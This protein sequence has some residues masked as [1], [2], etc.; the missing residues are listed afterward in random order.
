MGCVDF[1]QDK[2]RWRA[3]LNSHEQPGSTKCGE[4]VD[5][6]MDCYPV[7]RTLL[8]TV[9]YGPYSD[10]FSISDYGSYMMDEQWNGEE[11]EGTGRE[12]L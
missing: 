7:K 12:L 2:Y 1:A 8:P 10:A 5:Q 11:M 9:S 6:L 4:S 3:H